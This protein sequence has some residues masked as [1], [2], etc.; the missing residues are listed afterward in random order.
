M[1]GECQVRVREEERGEQAG[2]EGEKCSIALALEDGFC[3][4][5]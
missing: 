2:S 1:Q 5:K 3:V 4:G